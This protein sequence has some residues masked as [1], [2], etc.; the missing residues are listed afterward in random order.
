[1]K[2]E[3][4][5]TDASLWSGEATSVV[6]PAAGGDMGILTGR[7]PVLAVLRPGKVR[8]TPSSGQVVT[9]DVH[10]GFVSVDEDVVT[11]V[12]DNSAVNRAS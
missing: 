8:I 2:V 4:V 12:V 11:V 5:S 1:M 7:Q 6:V 3:V 10:E 9:L